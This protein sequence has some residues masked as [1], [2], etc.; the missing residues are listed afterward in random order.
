MVCVALGTSK[1][2]NCSTNFFS[3]ASHIHVY[4]TMLTIE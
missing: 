1:F 3:I 2:Y 4:A